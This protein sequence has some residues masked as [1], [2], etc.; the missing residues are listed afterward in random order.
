MTAHTITA[1]W[2]SATRIT[3]PSTR[4]AVPD[5]GSVSA[6]T[7]AFVAP[8]P[9]ISRAKA[10][11]RLLPVRALYSALPWCHWCAS[12]VVTLRPPALPSPF[13]CCTTTILLLTVATTTATAAAATT[14]TVL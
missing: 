5:P 2:P 6:T 4:R 7:F 14:T 8:T 11:P 9:A 12:G 13:R 3:R 10:F 1:R